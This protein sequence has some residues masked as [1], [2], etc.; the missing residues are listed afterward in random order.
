MPGP[1][2]SRTRPVGNGS[3][4]SRGTFT[5]CGLS[6]PGRL[7]HQHPG[8]PRSQRIS[9]SSSPGPAR[10]RRRGRVLPV[11]LVTAASPALRF[12]HLD[13]HSVPSCWPRRSPSPCARRFMVKP[14]LP[15]RGTY[16]RRP[17]DRA[18]RPRSGIPGRPAR[19][20]PRHC[21]P[22]LPP[23]PTAGR[24]KT[25][26][27]RVLSRVPSVTLVAQP[28]SPGALLPDLSP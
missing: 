2:S 27:E 16:C 20:C 24:N 1:R 8:R 14:K 22:A 3:S 10:P 25:T 17:P 6:P 9:G 4:P 13:G 7:L 19:R 23:G 21:V 15:P 11:K 26:P 12:L 5:P 18:A 28:S